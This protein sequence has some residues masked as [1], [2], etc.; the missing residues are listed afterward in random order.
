MATERTLEPGTA[1]HLPPTVKNVK[2]SK[3]AFTDGTFSD[4]ST[5]AQPRHLSGFDE[6]MLT[7]KSQAVNSFLKFLD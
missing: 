6:L 5:S 3:D 4:K 7:R 1:R 2:F